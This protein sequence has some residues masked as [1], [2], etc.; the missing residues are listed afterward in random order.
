MND[1]QA[2]QT[3]ADGPPLVRFSEAELALFETARDF[4]N[5]VAA[6]FDLTFSD[7]WLWLCDLPDEAMSLFFS[8]KG[9]S[10][11]AEAVADE[12][13]PNRDRTLTFKPALSVQ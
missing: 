3:I 10:A 6:H 13:A 11:M 5:A 12:F 8:A 1:A 2:D 9:Q 7:V 4:A